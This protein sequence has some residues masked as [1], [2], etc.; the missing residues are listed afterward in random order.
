[1]VY[2]DSNQNGRKE[3][4]EKGVGQVAVS[5]GIDVVLT[6]A[7]GKYQLP[8]RENSIFFVIKPNGYQFPLN[9][10][11]IPKFYHVH[12]PEGSPELRYKGSESTGRLPKS[13]DFALLKDDK[14]QKNFRAL[15]FGDPQAY[16]MDEI[17]YFYK[18]VVQDVTGK[19]RFSFGLSLGDLVGNDLTLFD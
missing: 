7:G 5:N 16:N 10:D 11:N 19:E 13:L 3:S 1:I 17:D 15:V 4:A 9:E 8:V 14:E 12:K 6:D 18:G 2:E